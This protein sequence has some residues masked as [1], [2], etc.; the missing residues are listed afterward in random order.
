[1]PGVPSEEVAVGDDAG[2]AEAALFSGDLYKMYL[3]YAEQKGWKTEAI[4]ESEGEQGG[5]KEVIVRIHKEGVPHLQDDLA[6]LLF[7]FLYG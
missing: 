1:M 2:G 7:E 4:S 3:R 5:F 6:D